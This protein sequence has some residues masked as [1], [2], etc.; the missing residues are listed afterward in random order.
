MRCIEARFVPFADEILASIDDGI[1]WL[2][3]ESYIDTDRNGKAVDMVAVFAQRRGGLWQKAYEYGGGSEQYHDEPRVLPDEYQKRYCDLIAA[4]TLGET[5][6]FGQ[7]LH[8]ATREQLRAAQQPPVNPK[9]WFAF[10]GFGSRQSQI[11]NALWFGIVHDISTGAAMERIGVH[12]YYDYP[13]A[14]IEFRDVMPLLGQYRQELCDQLDVLMRVRLGVEPGYY[15]DFVAGIESRGLVFG[16]LLAQHLGLPF[17]AI[18][19]AGK[20][21]RD[22]VRPVARVEYEKEYGKDALEIQPAHLDSCL[23]ASR[24]CIL[25]D[26]VLATGGSIAAAAALLRECGAVVAA[27]AVIDDVAS[28]RSVWRAK[29]TKELPSVPIVSLF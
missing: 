11:H 2:A 25:V 5:T 13:T 26:D 1:V 22:T 3:I 21:P 28:L 19:K 17:V 29:L 10:A 16:A 15:C 14:G 18:R 27:V 4:R 24:K 9:D 23:G 12:T 6:T 8:D 7:L 20:L